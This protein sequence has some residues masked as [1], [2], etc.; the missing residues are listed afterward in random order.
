MIGAGQTLLTYTGGLPA[1]GDNILF[2]SV[3]AFPPGGSF[4]LLGQ[5]WFQIAVSADTGTTNAIRAEY[6]LAGR[7]TVAADWVVFYQSAALDLTPGT[8]ATFSDEIFVGNYKDIRIVFAS[9][10]AQTAFQCNMGMSPNRATAVKPT[11]TRF[12]EGGAVVTDV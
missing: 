6:S 3:T 12:D 4:H 5:S 1:N 10:G 8:L 2:N 7:N 11:H 9:N